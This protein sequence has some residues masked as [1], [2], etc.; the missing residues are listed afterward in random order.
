MVSVENVIVILDQCI[1]LLDE[2]IRNVPAARALLIEL[3]EKMER[4]KLR[5]EKNY[6]VQELPSQLY[7][8]DKKEIVLKINELIRFVNNN[9]V[10]RA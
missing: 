5:G 10:H 9:T 4:E 2:K 8:E 3:L 1:K 7:N 6:R